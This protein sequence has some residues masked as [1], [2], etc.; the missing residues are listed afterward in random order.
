MKINVKA[1]NEMDNK[2][3]GV[4]KVIPKIRNRAK[5]VMGKIQELPNLSTP[6]DVLTTS[7]SASSMDIFIF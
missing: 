5:K 1:M 3:E 4:A 6:K 2:L 7:T